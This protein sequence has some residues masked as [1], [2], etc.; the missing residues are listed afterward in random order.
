MRSSTTL[1]L[2][3]H[4]WRREKSQSLK[5]AEKSKPSKLPMLETISYYTPGPEY[6]SQRVNTMWY[7]SDKIH[8][9][10]PLPA[11]IVCNMI[12]LWLRIIVQ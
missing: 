12:I 5:K 3:E 1:T 4:L 11:L 10:V 9:R 7:S 8:V 6:W 2:Y